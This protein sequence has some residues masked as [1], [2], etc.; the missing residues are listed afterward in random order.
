MKPELYDV[1]QA[2]DLTRF[3]RSI[4][5]AMRIVVWA[6]VP[7]EV[8]KLLDCVPLPEAVQITGI[9]STTLRNWIKSGRLPAHEHE[10]RLVMRL[11]DIKRVIDDPPAR[12][13]PLMGGKAFTRW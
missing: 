7:P 6:T 2:L 5:P 11:T 3:H 8:R 1:Q 4:P 9:H 10:G 13:R 12:G